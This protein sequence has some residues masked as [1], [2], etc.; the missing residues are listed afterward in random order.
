MPCAWELPRIS[1][2]WCLQMKASLFIVPCTYP[3]YYYLSIEV[4]LGSV[5][6]SRGVDRPLEGAFFH[7]SNPYS[8]RRR[9]RSIASCRERF[10]IVGV[11]KY[12]SF[13]VFPIS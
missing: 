8:T 13:R 2:I 3:S 9:Q 1:S 4:T 11:T 6:L 10:L 12:S 5:L 7:F